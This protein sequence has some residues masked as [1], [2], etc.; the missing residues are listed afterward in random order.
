MAR[1]R[2]W[3]KLRAFTLI[4]LLV[5]IAIIAILIGLLLPAVQK[6]REA[7]ARSQSL[8]NL[9]QMSLALHDCDSAQGKLP[10]SSGYFPGYASNGPNGGDWSGDY[11]STADN[12]GG[13]TLAPA[14][15][16]SLHFFI[17]PYMEED[18]LY[19]TTVSDSWG[20]SQPVK[21]YIT[22]QDPAFAQGTGQYDGR[23]VTTYPSNAYV[24]NSN[25]SVGSINQWSGGA[26]SRGGIANIMPD[27][28]SQTIVFGEHYANCQ[29]Y[30]GYPTDGTAGSSMLAFESNFDFTTGHGWKNATIISTALPQFAPKG[31]TCDETRQ[32]AHSTGGILVGMGDGSCRS[33]SSGISQ[34]TWAA[35]LLP[36]DGVVLGSDW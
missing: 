34:G 14:H 25:G 26:S 32:Q 30:S 22:P 5:V 29:F 11:T 19:R 21:K 13:W 18:N 3:I 7:A 31:A 24:F 20:I 36:N 35:A 12:P 1:L 10:P 9:H 17:L 28:T 15:K 33:V 8:N 27:G 16:G 2:L 23:P 6:V 4:E